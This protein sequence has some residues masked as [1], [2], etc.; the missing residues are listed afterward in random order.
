MLVLNHLERTTATVTALLAILLVNATTMS[1]Q[2]CKKTFIHKA[3]VIDNTYIVS[4]ILLHSSDFEWEN[5]ISDRGELFYVKCSPRK[6]AKHPKQSTA[7][8]D[9]PKKTKTAAGKLVKLLK[10]KKRNRDKNDGSKHVGSSNKVTFLDTQ[11]RT[12]S[13]NETGGTHMRALD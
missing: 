9:E 6:L 8:N 4:T 7:S 10:R 12:T 3:N 11:V 2:T 1:T 5:E 13:P